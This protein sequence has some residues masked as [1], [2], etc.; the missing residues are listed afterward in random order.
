MTIKTIT[1]ELR[2][3]MIVTAKRKAGV[4]EEL[5]NIDRDRRE[6]AEACI[7]YACGGQDVIDAALAVQAKI[8]ELH[9]QVPAVLRDRNLPHYTTD[10]DTKSANIGGMRVLLPL[11]GKGP[12]DQ[13]L[14]P[15]EITIP[16]NHP[17]ADRFHALEARERAAEEQG[18]RIGLA[19]SSAVAA[20]GRSVKKLLA[21]WPEAAEL[22]PEKEARA[23]NLPTVQA[24]ELNKM[25]GLPSGGEK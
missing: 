18:R 16:G 3:S 13:S 5:E 10:Y 4:I 7:V 25:I 21:A 22:L 17:L 12:H 8:D 14:C 20:A 24:A 1:I 9:M 6:H 19:I 2:D 23:V 11:K 15:N